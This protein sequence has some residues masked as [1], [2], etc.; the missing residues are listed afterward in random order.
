MTVPPWLAPPA[1]LAPGT[2]VAVIGGGVAGSAAARALAGAGLRPLLIERH[3]DLGQDASGNPCG[4]LKPRLTA[5]GGLHGRF[6]GQAYLRA[7]T[8]LDRLAETTPEVWAGRGLLAVARDTAERD[9][10]ERLHGTL[11]AGEAV[12]VGAEEAARLSGVAAP[13]G[14]LWYPRGGSIRPPVVCAALARG[15]PRLTAT[16]A[17]LERTGDVWRLRDGAGAILTEAGAVVLCAGARLPA[18]VPDAELPLHANRGQITLM[19]ALARPPRAAITFGGYVTPPVRL[20]GTAVQVVGA[21]YERLGPAGAATVDAAG[22]SAARPADDT[23]I[24]DL[25]ARHLPDLGAAWDGVAPV[26]ARVAARTTVADHMPLMGPLTAAEAFRRAYAEL[27]HGRR[28]DRYPAAPWTPGLFMLGGLGSRG[29]QTAPLLAEAL[30]AMMSGAP[31]PLAEDLLAAVHPAR[32][33][34][35]S[36]RKAPGRRRAGCP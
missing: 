24:L 11:P 31:S 4:L 2:V 30:A 17:A 16:V 25:L 6:Y 27:H 14:G 32:F 22:W 28:P 26:G 34:V 8:T 10:M 35:R 5:D 1:P 13:L 21:T 9:T 3:A 18:L 7:C 15:V 12:P 19:P 33:L 23:A 29:F 20:D 36:L